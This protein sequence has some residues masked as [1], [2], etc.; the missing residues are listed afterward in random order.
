MIHAASFTIV[1]RVSTIHQQ[2]TVL[3]DGPTDDQPIDKLEVH[4]GLGI[5]V[6]VLI[7]AHLLTYSMVQSPS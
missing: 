4:H 5:F 6:S 7:T 3:L 1:I 2:R